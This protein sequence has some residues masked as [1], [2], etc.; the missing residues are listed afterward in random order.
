M[1]GIVVGF[2]I[3]SPASPSFSLSL[4]LLFFCLPSPPSFPPFAR[5]TRVGRIAIYI[6]LL[7]LMNYSSIILKPPAST[8][9]HHSAHGSQRSRGTRKLIA[10]LCSSCF[11]FLRHSQP[12]C[13]TQRR[14]E[15]R[16]AHGHP[17]LLNYTTHQSRGARSPR[18]AL[19]RTPSPSFAALVG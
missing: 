6:S 9:H 10:H 15:L 17:R 16:L 3:S 14:D 13:H 2:V 18:L 19:P 4:F 1:E 7:I 5:G 8:H 11:S 12:T